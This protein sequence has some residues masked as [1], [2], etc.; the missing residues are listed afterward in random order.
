M[1]QAVRAPRSLSF[2]IHVY[3]YS[4][5]G[6]DERVRAL[7]A[8]RKKKEKQ[9]MLREPPCRPRTLK[10]DLEP[11]PGASQRPHRPNMP[12]NGSFLP[13]GTFEERDKT[14]GGLRTVS[15]CCKAKTNQEQDS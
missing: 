12:C 6:V 7:R 9:G 10:V 13:S 8:E 14:N 1:Y 11:E 2:G 5:A 4:R 15:F 3:A